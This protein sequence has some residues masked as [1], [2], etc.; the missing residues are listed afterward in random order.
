VGG[1]ET[2]VM[3]LA[4]FVGAFVN[5]VTGL[6]S[7]M[8]ALPLLSLVIVSK[9]MIVV[10]AI[11]GMLVAFAALAIYWKVFD[12]RED[13]LFWGCYALGAPFGLLTLKT[14]DIHILQ[15]LLG[16]QYGE[17]NTRPVK[18]VS[19]GG[20]LICC[21]VTP[22]IVVPVLAFPCNI[23]GTVL[24]VLSQNKLNITYLYCLCNDIS[25]VF[26][27]AQYSSR[28]YRFICWCQLPGHK[29][30]EISVCLPKHRDGT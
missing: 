11:C 24:S 17:L 7:A 14:V 1:Q 5:G 3:M 25:G 30:P 23:S 28:I 26:S 8:V 12:F 22:V 29:K 18:Q 6:G 21:I 15:L 2:A 13:R 16:F 19:Q 4:W 20:Q 27:H 9:D 10:S